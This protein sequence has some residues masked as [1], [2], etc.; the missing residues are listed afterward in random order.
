MSSIL[1]VPFYSGELG[2]E[3]LNY[4]PHVNYLA[5]KQQY[6]EVHV[7]VKQGYQALYPMGTH[8]HV[9]ELFGKDNSVGNSGYGRPPINNAVLADLKKRAGGN[10][11]VV[12]DPKAGMSFYKK[13]TFLQY[14][15]THTCNVSVPDNSVV[16][17]IRRRKFASYKNWEADNWNGLCDFL[18]E[19]GF[20]VVIVGEGMSFDVPSYCYDLRNKTSMGDFINIVHQSK[21]VVGQSTGTT[22]LTALCGVLH[23]VWGP[24]RIKERYLKSWN[25]FGAPVEFY[26]CNRTSVSRQENKKERNHKEWNFSLDEVTRLIDRTIKRL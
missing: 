12:D 13:R 8:F 18:H 9:G 6:D 14:K 1:F 7:I 21:F 22:H 19:K 2:W 15:T 5:E 26:A 17:C 16:L 20:N 23:A 24:N 25:P 10:L 3:L 11:S 4:I